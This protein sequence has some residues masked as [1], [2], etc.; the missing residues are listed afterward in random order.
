MPASCPKCGKPLTTIQIEKITIIEWS[1]EE[2][3]YYNNGQG[4]GTAK[5]Y[6]CG[7]VIGGYGQMPLWGIWPDF[8]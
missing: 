5:C 8:E 4:S 1:Q 2:E 7:K 6:S 3:E